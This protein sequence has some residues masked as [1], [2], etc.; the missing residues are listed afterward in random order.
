MKKWIEEKEVKNLEVEKNEWK[1][2]MQ[3][4]QDAS[5]ETNKTASILVYYP[6]PF[7][8]NPLADFWIR[9]LWAFAMTCYVFDMALSASA[10][11]LFLLYYPTL[12]WFNPLADVWIRMLWANLYDLLR[13][14][15]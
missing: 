11:A 1:V 7:W 2:Q 13:N 10:C 4:L 12:F 8:F 3:N 14:G 6:T 5:M 9:I 15:S